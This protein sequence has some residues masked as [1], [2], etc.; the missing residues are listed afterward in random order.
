MK[1]SDTIIRPMGILKRAGIGL[2]IFLLTIIIIFGSYMLYL[3][4]QYNRIDDVVLLDIATPQAAVLMQDT[5]YTAVTYNIGF[6]AYDPEYSFFMDKGKMSDGTLVVGRYGKARSKAAAHNNTTGSIDAITLL[7]PDFVLIQ[8]A[9]KNATRSFYIN[10]VQALTDVF[11]NHSST[12]ASNFHSA[13]LALPITDMH[14]K[15]EAGLVTMSSYKVNEAFRYSYPVDNSFPAKFF[16]LDRCFTVLR[17]PVHNTL[18]NSSG[19]E[20]VLINSHMSAYDKGGTIRIQQL[21][22]LNAMLETE[23]S[24]GNY[25]IV[26]GDFNHALYGSETTFPSKQQFPDWVSILTGKDIAKGFTVVEP[27]NSKTVPTC[28]TCDLPYE[29]DVNFVVSVDGFIIS[30]NIKATAENVSLD[31]AYSDHNPVKLTFSLVS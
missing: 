5:D 20:L 26:G 13:F 11:P 22:H 27:Y 18:G 6:G 28:R 30:S 29:K 19:K 25:V 9:D 8:E 14:G 1:K 24:K 2:G 15:V 7:S 17:L 16:D 21:T 23:Y 31:F 3:I 12:Y 4:F 10:Q